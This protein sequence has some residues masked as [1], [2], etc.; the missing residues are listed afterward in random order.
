MRPILAEISANRSR[1]GELSKEARA[2]VIAAVEAGQSPTKVAEQ[3]GC[4]RRTIYST[5]SRFKKQH[6]N[7][8]KPRNGRPE[9]LQPRDKRAILR[10]L[11][12]KPEATYD[13]ICAFAGVNVSHRTLCRLAKKHNITRVHRASILHL[14][15][16]MTLTIRFE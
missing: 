4:S 7:A 10:L 12:T 1:G 15:K 14:Q 11:R 16:S 13:D 8:S 6:H 2:A 3:I 5:I 9:A